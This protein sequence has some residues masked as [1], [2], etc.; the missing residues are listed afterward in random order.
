MVCVCVCVCWTLAPL[1]SPVHQSGMMIKQQ[2]HILHERDTDKK[3]KSDLLCSVNLVRVS[4]VIQRMHHRNFSCRESRIG[5]GS[6]SFFQIDP[7]RER[8]VPR[9]PTTT[10][11]LCD[12]RGKELVTSSG[13]GFEHRSKQ[14]SLWQTPQK[15]RRSNKRERE[16]KSVVHG[17]CAFTTNTPFFCFLFHSSSP[18]FAPTP[19]LCEAFSWQVEITN[20][21]NPN[22][23]RFVIA[24]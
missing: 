21:S 12:L 11:R 1:H 23:F 17:G 9:E 10:H 7:N 3:T 13:F 6:L 19:N 14:T 18:F 2:N 16:I 20:F 8:D 24:W 4:F 5:L 22:I 15:R